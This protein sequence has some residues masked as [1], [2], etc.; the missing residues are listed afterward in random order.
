L[1][2]R[3]QGL[4]GSLQVLAFGAL[5][6]L[7]MPQIIV[8]GADRDL[9]AW[10]AFDAPSLNRPRTITRPATTVSSYGIIPHSKSLFA[11]GAAIFLNDFSHS[12]QTLPPTHTP[13]ELEVGPGHSLA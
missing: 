9:C 10:A 12:Q 1:L 7:V 13:E 5:E 4:L 2:A 11:M 3:R 8:V 6:L